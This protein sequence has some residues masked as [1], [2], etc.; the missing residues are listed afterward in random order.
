MGQDT[1]HLKSTNG[2]LNVLFVFDAVALW[3]GVV[4][5]RKFMV[6]FVQNVVKETTS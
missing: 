5:W 6:L 4:F 2:I 1:F 3:L